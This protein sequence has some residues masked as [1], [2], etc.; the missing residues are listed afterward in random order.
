MKTRINFYGLFLALALLALLV[1]GCGGGQTVLRHDNNL[2]A[3]GVRSQ[4]Q[5]ANSAFEAREYEK[6]IRLYDNILSRYES[7][8]HSL[9]VAIGTDMA[10][11]S[12]E[13]GDR[14]NF[15]RYAMEVETRAKSLRHIPKNSQL[16]LTLLHHFRGE[17]TE[18]DLRVSARLY[19]AVNTIL[20]GE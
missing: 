12:L 14:E 2:L 15:M 16:V 20:G 8:D 1:S 18:R 19:E 5:A 7:K 4:I 3:I 10:L 17:T 6:A 9:E 11:A 13:I